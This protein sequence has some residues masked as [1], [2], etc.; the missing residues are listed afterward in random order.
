[1]AY[2]GTIEVMLR[3]TLFVTLISSV[4]AAGPSLMPLPVTVR[5]ATGKLTLDSTFKAALTGAPDA[6]LDA[7]VG[8]FVTRLSGRTGIPMPGLKDATPK[9]RIEC[10]SA[11][12]D[13]P[14]LGEDESYTLDVTSEG[15]LLK[16]PARAGA[17]HGLET[18]GQLVTLGKD[19]FE[20]PV[21]HIEDN[22]RFPWRGLML[23]SSRHWMPLEVVKR[24]LDAMAAVKL[25]VFHWHLSDDQ[26]FR[27]E[28]KRFPK[29]QQ[30]GSDGLFYTQD[31]IRGVVA[32]A[33][34]RGIRVVPE[35]DIPGHTTAWL[36]GY[37]ELGT[38]PG[39]YEI[40]RHWGIYEN[41]LDP[42][43]EETYTF[44]DAFFE[45]MTTLFPDPYFHV[46]GDE[47]EA[48][49][50]NASA[51]VQAW[52]KQNNLKDAH[53]IQAYFNQRVQKLLTKRGKILIGWDEVLHPDLPKDIVVQSWRGQ[54]SL[55][56]AAAQGYR[57]ILS[58]GYYLDHLSTAAFHYG[59]DPMSGDA[60]SLSPEQTKRIMGGEMC[61][62][63]EYATS[64]TVDSRIWP[65]A[66]VIAER[67][68]SPPSKD[69]DSMYARM[70][71][72]SRGLEW[73]GVQHRANYAPMLERMTAGR[74][75][76]ALRVL[77]DAVEGLGLGPRARAGKYT[78]LT[79]MNRLADAARPESESVRAMELAAAK[80]VA[81]P[82]G[83]PA[84]A[85]LLRREFARWA[86]NDARFQ[87]LAVDR[88]LLA[89]LLPLSRDLA[90]LGNAGLKLLDALEKGQT[91][92][93]GFVATQTKEITRMEKPAAE[94]NLAATRP[95]KVLLK[96][97]K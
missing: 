69:V 20:V 36:V 77:A 81:D 1:M 5:P 47:V 34:D 91:P 15:A 87:E 67:L 51:R 9:L 54:K 17:L 48:K 40:G 90:A 79:P 93:A 39:P 25:N 75:T 66:A 22:P 59:V 60:D 24:N 11:G 88:P 30:E 18:F 89:E 94:V 92:E 45:E 96:G 21:V 63:V 19:G 26:G 78:S 85:A 16:A 80:V 65:R 37:P 64:E 83:S 32:Y 50:W 72:V 84:E 62:W 71:A 43:R 8:R 35:F 23:D 74:P 68:W 53:A 31:E 57:G 95:V 33:R 97:G 58:W 73:T 10:A 12:N 52:A 13:Y 61:M 7:A 3:F 70:E 4:S 42:S 55:A 14:T 49:Q 29:L 46:G 2:W 44:L 38:N 56:E 86:A 27:V 28:S 41:A 6:R 82:K 76:D